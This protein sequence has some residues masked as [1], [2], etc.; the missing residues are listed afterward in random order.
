MDQLR[1]LQRTAS[2]A[3]GIG[4]EAEV[5]GPRRGALSLM[6]AMYRRVDLRGRCTSPT[7]A[8]SIHMSSTHAWPTPHGRSASVSGQGVRVTGF[9]LSAR[10]E[11]RPR[12]DGGRGSDRYRARGV[13]AA[14]SGGPQCRS[15]GRRVRTVDAGGSSAHR[16]QG[17]PGR[18]AAAGDAVLPGPGQ[19]GLWQGRERRYGVRGVRDSTHGL[20]GRTASLGSTRPGRCR[21]ISRGSRHSW[22][23]RSG[24][25]H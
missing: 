8:I 22:P 19:L 15:D 9:D 23:E 11:V 7:M 3:R 18:G 13:N 24:V 10:R 2:R 14:G 6:P 16:P 4:L 25:S 5:I 17:R 20:A 21:R 12:P 1:E